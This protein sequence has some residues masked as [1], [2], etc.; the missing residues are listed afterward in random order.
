M[1]SSFFT[2]GDPLELPQTAAMATTQRYSLHML[3]FKLLDR[4][5]VNLSIFGTKYNNIIFYPIGLCII[6]TPSLGGGDCAMKV[7]P[8]F[9]LLF[10]TFYFHLATLTLL[11]GYK[12]ALSIL[13][14]LN[15][16]RQ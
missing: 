4:L 12:S 15:H 9:T 7:A 8:H 11:V 2:V 14:Q 5:N 13:M 16:I 6:D 10:V 1:L 3:V